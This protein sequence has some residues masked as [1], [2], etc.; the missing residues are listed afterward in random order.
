MATKSKEELVEDI[1]K[2]RLKQNNIKILRK[3]DSIN[4]EID[5]ALK[6][7]ES[8]SGGKGGNLPDIKL[9]LDNNKGR[10]IPVMIEI[11]GTKGKLEKLE[12]DNT[13]SQ[14]PTARSQFATNGAIHYAKAI[15]DN[16]PEINEVIAVGINGYGEVKK[17]EIKGYY[18]AR[19]NG[20]VPKE[21]TLITED[22]TIFK[23]VNLD[24]LYK[25]LDT[26]FL[27]QQEQEEAKKK[28]ETELEVNIKAIHQSI[29]DDEA[30]R[31]VLSTNEKLYLFCGL[32]MAGLETKG[33]TPL[34]P[35]EMHSND[36]QKYHDGTMILSQIEA[37]M[38]QRG[39]STEKQEQVMRLLKPVFNRRVLYKS[40]NGTS[41]LKDLFK[42]VKNDIIPIFNSPFHLD[43]MGRILNSLTDWL[44]IENDVANDVVLT[45]RY[46]TDLMARLCRT[47]KDSLVLDSTMG[48]GGF[49]VS[50]M[51][52]MI[53]DAQ[54]KIKDEDELQKKIKN[55]KENQL[56]G[57]EIL[58]NIYIL[59]VLNMLLMGDGSSNLICDDANNEAFVNFDNTVYLL[60]PPYSANGKGLCFVEDA[61]SHMHSGY[62]CVLIQENAGSG[63]G[64]PYAKRILE[65][66][67]LL[68]SIHMP[69][70]LFSGKASVQTAIYLFKV[71]EPHNK[72]NL[73]KFIDFSNDGYTRQNRKKSSQDVNLRDTDN[74]K[75]R[76]KEI[77][78]RLTGKKPETGYYT[79]ENGL[80]I[81][82]TISLEGDDWT[83]AKHKIIDTTP[84]EED[85]KKTVADYL[86][87]QVSNLMR[88]V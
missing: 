77:V 72:D 36:N 21:I 20:A 32:I 82:D 73:V 56:M 48:S 22:L 14:K 70:K 23:D 24:K 26:L 79:T 81:E 38:N 17:L 40:I 44:A 6:K 30:L 71:N 1:V 34:E 46:I 88:G 27:T 67:T 55:I 35:S 43:F 18:V 86:S 75:A 85:F 41:V 64:L 74:A 45:P 80:L 29:Y 15:L 7:A 63:Q 28:L 37:F 83:F 4:K 59:A 31:N 51:D 8:K 10:R 52:I 84:T 25:H 33:M 2:E 68:A 39:C 16:V 47:N 66:N 50:A 3:T 5:E 9:Y 65:K 42:Q 62:G 54:D 19:T 60:N 61:L 12:K 57:I 78:A 53:R 87:W 69:D 11:K 13:I 49:L 58:E 76:Y